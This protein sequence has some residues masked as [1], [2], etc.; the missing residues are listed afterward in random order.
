MSPVTGSSRRKN[1][2]RRQMFLFFPA[3][4]VGANDKLPRAP[5]IIAAFS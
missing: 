4:L 2:A 5:G 1:G 3:R